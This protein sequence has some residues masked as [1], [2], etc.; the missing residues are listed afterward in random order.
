MLPHQ[1]IEQGGFTGGAAAADGGHHR[2][3]RRKS[4]EQLGID[5]ILPESD[6]RIVS[7]FEQIR[8]PG[9][10]VS[11]LPEGIVASWFHSL[12]MVKVNKFNA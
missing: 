7:N 1:G 4:G 11:Q 2:E 5:Y 12:N 3:V 9:D 8:Q 10:M 6:F